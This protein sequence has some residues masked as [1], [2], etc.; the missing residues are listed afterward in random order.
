MSEKGWY[1]PSEL[2]TEGAEA[3]GVLCQ[4]SIGLLMLFRRHVYSN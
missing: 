4:E 1:W 3:I 2:S